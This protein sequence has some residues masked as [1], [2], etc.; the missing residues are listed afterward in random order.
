MSA[1]TMEYIQIFPFLDVS[2]GTY[3]MIATNLFII[4]CGEN[5]VAY[6]E[7]GEIHVA[8]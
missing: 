4:I 5:C 6:M 1:E 7:R 2:C 3:A 8:H